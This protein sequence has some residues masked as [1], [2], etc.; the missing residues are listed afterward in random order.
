[1]YIHFQS[2]TC[3]TPRR[4]SILWLLPSLTGYRGIG[5]ATKW[6]KTPPL[7]SRER[8]VIDE[9]GNFLYLDF[10]VDL[11]Q[12]VFS[13]QRL[14]RQV[15]NGAKASNLLFLNCDDAS[16]PHDDVFTPSHVTL[17]L[18]TACLYADMACLRVCGFCEMEKKCAK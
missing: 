12:E 18:L 7:S 6:S 1:M 9:N 3:V 15:M 2:G 13:L 14:V 17:S 11:M 10:E 5:Y 8:D 4:N 16:S